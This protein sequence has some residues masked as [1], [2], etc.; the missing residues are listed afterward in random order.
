MQLI[1]IKNNVF[2]VHLTTWSVFSPILFPT[3]VG[4]VLVTMW[5]EGKVFVWLAPVDQAFLKFI[6]CFKYEREGWWDGSVGKSTWL[7]FQAALP[8]VWSS[9]PS[10]HMVAHNHP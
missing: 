5:Q 4:G 9:N 6:F 10:N 8:K 3:V 1:G 7:L 2:E